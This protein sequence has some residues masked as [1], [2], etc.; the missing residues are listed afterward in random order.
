[1]KKLHL[2][3]TMLLLCAL[4]VG[5]SSVWAQTVTIWSEDFSG[6]SADDVPSGTISLPHTGTSVY[7]SGT[8]SYSC[9]DGGSTTKI[10][11]QNTG[12]HVAPELLVSKTNGTFTATIPLDNIE[13]TLTLTYYQNKQKLKVESTTKGVTGGQ[14]LKPDAVGQQTTTF[15][16]ITTSMKEIVIVFTATGSSNVRLD[17]IV[18]TGTHKTASPLASI[19]L[20][21]TYQTVFHQGDTFNHDGMTV[22]ATYEDSSNKD[23]TEDAVFSSPDMST[24]G[25]KTVTVTYTENDVEKS[26][27]YDITVNEPATLTSIALSG[28]Y[29]TEFTEGD[30]FTNEGIVVTANYD[31]ETSKIVT[32]STTFTG[33]NMSSVGV[34]TVTA[35]YTENEV[36]KTTTYDI[37]VNPHIQPTTVTIQM[38]NSLF[39]E[40]V[41][42]SGK[43][44]ANLTFSGTQDGVT[45][46]YYV[47]NDSYYYF[48]TSNTRPYNTCTLDYAAP[49]GY[50]ITK[51]VFTSDGSNWETATPSVGEMTATKQWEGIA[52]N[53]TFSWETSGTRVKTVVVSLAESATISLNAACNDGKGNIYGTYSNSKSFVVPADLTVSAVKVVDGKLVVTNY[54]EDDIVPAN[55]GVM[56]SSTVAGD[57]TILLSDEAGEE[58][59]GNML[60]ASSVAMTGDNLFYRLTM[61]NPATDNKIGFWWGAED[62]AAFVIAAN[63]AYLAVPSDPEARDFVWF[64]EG[65]TT[66]LS[67]VRGLKSEVRGEYFNLNGQRVAQPTKGLYI[68]NGR[69]VVI[70]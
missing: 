37:I 1:M 19:A 51:I 18:L 50:V 61:H 22:T 48:N 20:S 26:T 69:K 24:T 41:H 11:N 10:Y 28:S 49:T 7:A 3:K 4:I 39:G 38:T 16:G 9:T 30:S 60:K 64:D 62:G 58:I 55:T 34:Q 46:T 56:V 36:T 65:E 63:K 44:T 29:Q 12:G 32:G 68:V 25:V 40:E 23:V 5:S 33:Y 8:L 47:P 57:H 27:S 52:G 21:G 6:Y 54:N 2:L 43:S 17:N 59:D 14:E 67:E 13:G 31:D 35:S 53:I 66:S 70:K 15:E 45:V 42:T